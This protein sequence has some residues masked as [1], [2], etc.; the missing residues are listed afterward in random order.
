MG[1]AI[2]VLG[3]VAIANSGRGYRAAPPL[4]RATP[5]KEITG[6]CDETEHDIEG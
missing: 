3:W 5:D 6:T 1:P 2:D 4:G